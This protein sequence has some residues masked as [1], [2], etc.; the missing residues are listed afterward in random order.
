MD[1]DKCASRTCGFSPSWHLVPSFL[2]GLNAG[3]G[4]KGG[5]V[6]FGVFDEPA[7]DARKLVRPRQEGLTISLAQP[8]S[9]QDAGYLPSS[10]FGEYSPQA[11]SM[12]L[13]HWADQ[14]RGKSNRCG[15]VL[16]AFRPVPTSYLRPEIVNVPTPP[17]RGCLQMI[18]LCSTRGL[19]NC[20]SSLAVCAI[21]PSS[22]VYLRKTGS[23]GAR[24]WPILLIDWAGG[25]SRRGGSEE[26]ASGVEIELG[27]RK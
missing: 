11:R 20:C 6:A 8:S 15:K 14:C 24:A 16:L 17:I 2:V 22:K 5:T 27:S 3:H 19:L 18:M 26:P 21:R 25:T 9:L 10:H 12:R 23:S 7:R 13:L 4:L 1:E